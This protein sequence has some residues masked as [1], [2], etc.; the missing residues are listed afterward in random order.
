MKPRAVLFMVV[1]CIGTLSAQT[2][3]G[4]IVGTVTDKSGAVIAGAQVTARN[5]NTGL[6]RR[7]ITSADG[8]YSITELPIG[9]YEVTVSQ[10]DF[11]TFVASG[12][13]VNVASH[14]R[15]DALL[16]PG[17]V[18]TQV[19]VS[20]E[21][22][23]Q[24]ETTT[25]VLGGTLTPV[26]IENAPV[27]GRDYTKLIFLNPGIAGSPDQVTDSPG[28]FGLF[29]MNGNRGRSNNFLLDGTD[30]NDGYRNLPAI[31]QPGVFG[32][33]ATILPVEAVGELRVLSNYEAE[34]GRNSGAIVNIV[35]KS[36]TNDWHGSVLEFFR[37]HN[38]GARNY[39][40]FEP[41]PKNPFHNHQFGASLGG[42][43]LKN[44]TFF[45]VNYEGQRESGAQA[46]LS[47]V[48]DPAVVQSLGGASNTVARAL[49]AKWPAPNI[50]G[51]ASDATGCTTP[52]L[53]TSTRFSNR[54]DSF[55]AKLDHNINANNLVTG[56]YYFADSDQSFPFAQLAAGLLPGFNTVTPTRVQL[57]SLSYVKVVSTSQV[58]EARLG[59]NR[60]VQGFFPE[61]RGLNPASLGLDTGV[62]SPFNFGLPKITVGDYSVIGATS[63]VP[64]Q[65]VDSNWHIVDNYSWKTGRHDLKL[66][67]EFRRTTIAQVFEP[68]FRGTLQFDDLTSFL[69]GIPDGGSQARGFTPRHT[70]Q[71]SHGVYLQDSFRWTP[72][73]TLNL[74]LRWDYFG[75]LGEKD[76]LLFRF[77]PVG[78]GSTVQ[79]G[80][81]GGPSTL[82]EPD[83]NNFAPRLAFVYDLTGEGKTVVRGGWGIFYDAFSQDMFIGHIPFN[84]TFCP[85]PAYPTSGPGAVAL[86]GV[87]GAALGSGLPL[88]SGFEANSN[89]DF[90]AVDPQMRTPYVQ[91]FNLNVQQA[92]GSRAVFQI[93]YVGSKGT[94]LFRF[95]DV[96]QP[97][98]AEITAADLTGAACGPPAPC[99]NSFS[100]PRRFGNFFYVNR[101][102]STASSIYHSLQTSLRVSAWHGLTQQANFV[103]GHSI[104]N[105][106]DLEDATPNFSQPN[107]SLAPELERSNSNF[108]VR[109]RFTWNFVY[110]FPTFK[111]ARARLTDGWGLEG[112]LTLQDGQPFH[113]N[114][115][116][117]GDY[118]GSGEGID[119]PDVIGPIR[120]GSVPDNFLD[121]S[122][123]KVPCTTPTGVDTDCVPGTRHFGNMGRNSLRGPSFK[124]LNLAISKTTAITERVNLQLRAESFNVLN[125]PNFANPV[126]PSFIADPGT[127]GVNGTFSGALPITT[128]GDVGIGNPFL[129]GGGPRGFQFAAK[130]SF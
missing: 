39:F 83:Y 10:K 1:L 104:D 110:E 93:G 29:S 127:P 79:V 91:N 111:G 105:A 37:N 53:S 25:N 2:F 19:V 81:N 107:N 34:Y 4:M 44:K 60:Y 36:G 38:V 96:N 54:I 28:S 80:S 67:Y 87:S 14:R 65:R 78:D 75:V 116:F 50:V 98:E 108:D 3:R 97:S 129:G 32:D 122:S 95:R 74:G 103:W 24:V 109:R 115:F 62:T 58:N 9:R 120:Y 128:T 18:E 88:F 5:V 17:Q 35:T 121:L 72:R 106:S 49:L 56:R 73:L 125:H 26:T 77:I 66:G 84:C 31:N 85:G 69:A 113:L 6:T 16:Q 63:G 43:I 8:S 13:V 124:E 70:F 112:T 33:P 123:F 48:P 40:N 47:C 82:Y 101:E 55:I 89:T 42:P 86:G 11:R 57:V 12:V 100:V 68:N 27:N 21:N 45:F 41:N 22:L 92:L 52:N 118:S 102:E 64:R 71:N 117:E 51:A 20:A 61:D 76:D 130:I 7:A 30:M 99:I 90:F 126:L 15:V 46:G 114:Q 119:R 59:W 23:P 94:K